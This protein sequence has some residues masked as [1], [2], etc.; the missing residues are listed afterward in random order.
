VAT[1]LAGQPALLDVLKLNSDVT[2]TDRLL[3]DIGH[4][5][6][7]WA[8]N[9]LTGII[10]VPT[11]P[12]NLTVVGGAGNN[13]VAFLDPMVCYV[14]KTGRID[15]KAYTTLSSSFFGG[16]ILLNIQHITYGSKF[17]C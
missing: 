14:V 4:S 11:L 16:V 15:G 5:N 1:V 17:G 9:F 6:N 3:V 10:N 12:F 2:G 13:T 7:K 8:V